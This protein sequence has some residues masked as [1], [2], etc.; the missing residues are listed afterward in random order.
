MSPAIRQSIKSRSQNIDLLELVSALLP[1]ETVMVRSQVIPSNRLGRRFAQQK[2]IARGGMGEV[3]QGYDTETSRLVAIKRLKPELL[4][5]NPDAVQRLR[6]EGEILQQLNH[7][8]IVK[9][10]DTIDLAAQPVI[11]M[12]YV[13]GGSLQDLLKKQPRLPLEQVLTIALELADALA[14]AHHQGVIH[15]DIKPSNVLLAEDGS[16]RLSD[17]GIAYLARSTERLTQEGAILGTT[18]YLS[19]EAWRGEELDQR[20]DIWS[21]GALLYE[22]LA[23]WPPFNGEQ[24]AAVVAAILHQPVP[25]LYQVRANVP[26]GLIELIE[27]MLTKERS[28]RIDSMRQVAAGLELI[29]RGQEL[30]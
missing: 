15:R 11:I 14:R 10:L 20:S 1:T 6:R 30:G 27:Q 26:S 18:V 7:P 4:A 8:N 24:V 17:F 21:F 28:L 5:D 29:R 19:P 16:P 23:G 2:L 3:Y 9:V 25:D 22:M 12:E 13:P